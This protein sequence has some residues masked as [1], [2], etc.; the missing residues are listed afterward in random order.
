MS[1]SES[2]QEAIRRRLQALSPFSYEA[3][4]AEVMV[5]PVFTCPSSLP[6]RKVAQEM[7]KRRISSA[8]IV[9]EKGSPV[10]IITERDILTKVVSQEGV[11]PDRTPA[12]A[13]MSAPPLTLTPRAKLYQ[14]L[15]LLARYGIKHLP[16]VEDDRVVGIITLRQIIRLTHSEPLVIIGQIEAAKG[17][18][19]LAELKAS[20]PALAA[21][22]LSIGLPATE[23]MTMVSLIH[24]DLHRRAFE[25]ALEEMNTPPPARFSLFLTGSHGR[26]EALLAPDQDHGL[27]LADYP[28]GQYEA[29]DGYFRKLAT[30]FGSLLEAIG[31][32]RCP[33]YIMA[34]NPLWRKRLSEWK[35]QFLIWLGIDAYHIVRYLTL[36][37]DA[38]PILGEEALFED[39]Q[40]YEIGLIQRH[41]NIIRQMYEEEAGH[42][43]P[44]GL[45]RQFITEKE[46]PYRGKL[47]LKQSGLI[48]VVE[49]VRVLALKAG[50]T[51]ASTLERLRSLVK[52]GVLS[53]EDAEYAE[54][55]FHILVHYAL[56]AQIDSW[57]RGEPIT[58][59]LDPRRLSA[60]DQDM[61]R[62]AFQAV[63][64]LKE[65]VDAA[66]GGLIL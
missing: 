58:F 28:D 65:L 45:F 8:V 15:S 7:A 5:S 11:D 9:S 14:A 49:A 51:E 30:R 13:I 23:I 35:A 52:R 55:A 57:Q 53:R 31:Y 39:L 50:I 54:H 27:I 3:P 46:G 19:E 16:V 44:L 38:S 36:I 64:R 10:G 29:V 59:Y 40:A 12:A 37:F 6:V 48:F 60:H 17:P 22:R 25:L 34:E 24:R 18:E 32:P 21:N 66:F 62:Y 42:K 1:R 33:G 41:H 61:L 4:V 47:N 2:S 20:L 56:Q 63:K 43:V 26:A